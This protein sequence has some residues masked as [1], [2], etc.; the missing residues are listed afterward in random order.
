M[1][2][3]SYYIYTY[4][5]IRTHVSC[6]MY[7]VIYHISSCDVSYDVIYYHTWPT[8]HLLEMKPRTTAAA[9]AAAPPP[10]PPPPPPLPPPPPPPLPPP[11]PP[12]PPPPTTTTTRTRTTTTTTRTRTTTTTT[13]RTT[14]TTT[15][16][17]HSPKLYWRLNKALRA[18]PHVNA[19]AG[20]P[21]MTASYSAISQVAWW[22][23]RWLLSMCFCPVR[24]MV[25]I[26]LVSQRP[27]FLDTHVLRESH[28][29][30]IYQSQTDANNKAR[31]CL[32]KTK[33]NGTCKHMFNFGLQWKNLRSH[34]MSTPTRRTTFKMETAMRLPRSI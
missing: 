30:K 27:C 9:A 34:E 11:P 5:Y 21:S 6:I 14:T 15:T 33:S 7:H 28:S 4:T 20:Y 31:T 12:P 3:E 26:L 23:H 2:L 18:L 16:T 17:I 22:I 1:L 25:H 24:N 19:H 13:T 8:I 32:E 10:P 29:S